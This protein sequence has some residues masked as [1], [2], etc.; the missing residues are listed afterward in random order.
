MESTKQSWEDYLKILIKFQYTPEQIEAV[1]D[2]RE[3]YDHCTFEM[4]SGLIEQGIVKRTRKLKKKKRNMYVSPDG[5]FYYLEHF[6]KKMEYA[7]HFIQNE[8]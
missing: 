5:F 3:S 6:N 8:E 2:V 1:K 4:F 7:G